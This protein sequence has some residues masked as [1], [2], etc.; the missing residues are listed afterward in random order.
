MSVAVPITVRHLNH[1]VYTSPE[2]IT[3]AQKQTGELE[4]R[5]FDLLLLDIPVA[6]QLSSHFIL[7]LLTISI[8]QEGRINERILDHFRLLGN[9]TISCGCSQR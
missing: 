1:F 6:E 5:T 4:K 7:F 9:T 3:Q 2:R 8:W